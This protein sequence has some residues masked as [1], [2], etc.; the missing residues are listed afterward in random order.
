MTDEF[1]EHVTRERRLSELYRRMG[2]TPRMPSA[3]DALRELCDELERVENEL[4]G[5]VKPDQIPVPSVA[6]GRM[7]CPLEDHVLRL[8]NGDILALTRG[9]RIVTSA[10][11]SIR[12]TNKVTQQVEFEK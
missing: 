1:G 7:Y 2:S 5:I 11:G 10:S 9:H 3:E 8:A 4:S 12:I 6:D